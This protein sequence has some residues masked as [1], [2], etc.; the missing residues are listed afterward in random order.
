MGQD[1][2]PVARSLAQAPFR[3]RADIDSP[4]DRE[5][6]QDAAQRS[7][8]NTHSCPD[9]TNTRQLHVGPADP[10]PLLSNDPIMACLCEGSA[11]ITIPKSLGKAS[12]FNSPNVEKSTARSCASQSADKS[13]PAGHYAVP[14]DIARFASIRYSVLSSSKVLSQLDCSNF[15]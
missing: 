8:F 7:A 5:L 9:E 13:H 3:G 1:G 10:C 14:L 6:Q 12:A 15:F 2:P 11:E 4:D